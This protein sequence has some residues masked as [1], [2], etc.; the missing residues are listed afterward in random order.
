MAVPAA[1]RHFEVER[2]SAHPLGATP[3]S[4]GENFSLFSGHATGVE[5]LLFAAHDSAQPSQV[6]RFDPFVNKTFH[7]W[8]LFVRGLPEG[9]HYAFRVDG[10]FDP[11]AG[12]RY[13]ANK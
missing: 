12:H 7:F 5:L 10:P 6:I 8:H 13:N 9:T 11:S 1:H 3:T 4:D 2:G